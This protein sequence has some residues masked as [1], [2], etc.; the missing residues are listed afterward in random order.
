MGEWSAL[1]PRMEVGG[2]GEG[3]A[4]EAGA[5]ASGLY[6]DFSAQ[7]QPLGPSVTLHSLLS[8]KRAWVAVWPHRSTALKA[9]PGDMRVT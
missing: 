2:S 4:G 5:Q 9:F 3:G 8:G 7:S 1:C 6:E